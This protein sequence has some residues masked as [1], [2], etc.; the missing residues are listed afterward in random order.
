MC[1]HTH[2]HTVF[3]INCSHCSCEQI[4][5]PRWQSQVW[6]RDLKEVMELSPEAHGLDL[7]S[8]G[9]KHW[10]RDKEH[11]HHL[12]IYSNAS[13]GAQNPTD[14]IINSKS[15]ALQ[16]AFSQDI[17]RFYCTM[18][19]KNHPNLDP[20]PELHVTILERGYKTSGAQPAPKSM[21]MKS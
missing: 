2:A 17:G 7:Q 10:S 19:F 5:V 8:F 1:K 15:I 14:Y 18:R 13:C 11:G 4:I 9:F 3:T 12:G 20:T 6:E 21:K 16:C